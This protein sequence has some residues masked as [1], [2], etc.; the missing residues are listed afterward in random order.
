MHWL[1]KT[2]PSP[3]CSPWAPPLH[4]PWIPRWACPQLPSHWKGRAL[5]WWEEMRRGEKSIWRRYLSPFHQALETKLLLTSLMWLWPPRMTCR[6]APTRLFWTPLAMLRLILCHCLH[7]FCH[8]QPLNPLP[9]P[10]AHPYHLLQLP[11]PTPHHPPPLI[12]RL[13]APNSIAELHQF[14]PQINC[15]LIISLTLTEEWDT[16][17][18]SV[19]RRTAMSLS[20]HATFLGQIYNAW[21]LMIADIMVDQHHIDLSFYLFVHNIS[22]LILILISMLWWRPSICIYASG[23][24]LLQHFVFCNKIFKIKIKLVDLDEE[25]LLNWGVS[26]FGWWCRAGVLLA[27]IEPFLPWENNSH[28]SLQSF[29]HS[30]L[31]EA[32]SQGDGNSFRL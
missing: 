24:N 20:M 28:M 21:R 30:H 25:V 22:L 18:S 15:P 26:S 17:F 2:S 9:L 13:S 11:L 3:F 14:L 7:P 31:C 27:V 4:S 29:R 6:L 32:H 5:L 23:P 8:H 12:G 10:Q 19:R 1:V 16:K